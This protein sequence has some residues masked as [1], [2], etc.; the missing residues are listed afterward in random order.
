MLHAGSTLSAATRQLASRWP[1]GVT[2][3]PASD[4][5]VE[6]WVQL[7][8]P[9]EPEYVHFE[10]WWVRLRGGGSPV[11]FH[12]KGVHFSNPSPGALSA[13]SDAD[14]IILAPSNPVVSIG[15]MLGFG[16]R[17]CSL[18]GI[19][20]LR[21]ALRAASAPVVGISPIIQGAPVRGMAD[22]CLNVVGTPVRSSAVANTYGARSG[23]GLLDGW[24]V[25]TSD[26]PELDRISG[27][28]GR[29]VPLLMSTRESSE[30]L[31]SEAFELGL[32]VANR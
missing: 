2:L 29:A 30:A 9:N 5:S 24:L 22:V 18:S 8:D 10:E 11:G 13:I 16:G 1:L 7:T 12:Q 4:Q 3:I 15:T 23:G 20:G 26:A 14:V 25:D 17:N 31:A 21:N 32:T 19:P 28:I 27:V 6:T